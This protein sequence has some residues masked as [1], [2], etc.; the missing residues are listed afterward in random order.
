MARS[1]GGKWDSDVKLWYIR[2]GNIK[3]AE[4]EKHIASDAQSKQKSI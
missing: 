2:Y 3:G 4:L 1:A